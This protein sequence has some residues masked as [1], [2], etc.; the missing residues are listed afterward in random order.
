[1]VYFSPF[2]YIVPRQ[3][4]ETLLQVEAR[5]KSMEEDIIS[6]RSERRKLQEAFEAQQRQKDEEE[7]ERIRQAKK[8]KAKAS[9]S[10]HQC[11]K[12][13]NRF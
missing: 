1:V 4:L 6:K 2:W 10:A 7:R 12:L 13:W 3:T 5:L 9:K 11:Y 8:G